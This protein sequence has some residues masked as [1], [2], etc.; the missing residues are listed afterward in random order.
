MGIICS[1]S[2][3]KRRPKPEPESIEKKLKNYFLQ[4]IKNDYSLELNIL[5]IG[6]NGIGKTTLIK[7][8]LNE[9]D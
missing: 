5:L 2:D 9:E 7:S 3:T 8:I 6:E 1:N 4:N